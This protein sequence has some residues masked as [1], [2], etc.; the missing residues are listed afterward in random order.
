MPILTRDDSGPRARGVAGRAARSSV[1]GPWG[2]RIAPG[3]RGS[4]PAVR[5]VPAIAVVDDAHLLSES[6]GI[7]VAERLAGART[8]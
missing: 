2:S 5:T 6:E 1:T 7:A 8:S 3:S 4:A